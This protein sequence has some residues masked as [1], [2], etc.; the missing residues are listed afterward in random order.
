MVTYTLRHRIIALPSCLL[1]LQALVQ[2]AQAATL[3][4]RGGAISL[5]QLSASSKQLLTVSRH[6]VNK[7]PA[8][9]STP[10]PVVWALKP[11]PEPAM[12]PLLAIAAEKSAAGTELGSTSSKGDRK[13]AAAGGGGKAASP[14]ATSGK[15]SK[16]V[17]V[18]GASGARQVLLPECQ[19]PHVGM[20]L[21]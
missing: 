16:Q 12:Q 15:G 7:L 14:G 21:R 10:A 9:L 2:F 17:P 19:S 8:L 4:A 3:A 13:A 11:L 1:C 18:A 5:Q 20:A 6:L